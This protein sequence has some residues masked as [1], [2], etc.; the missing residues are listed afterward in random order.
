VSTKQPKQKVDTEE[1]E[2]ESEKDDQYTTTKK[3]KGGHQRSQ[4]E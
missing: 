2:P 4:V 1:E 3:V